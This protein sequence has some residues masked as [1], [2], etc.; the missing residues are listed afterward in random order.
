MNPTKVRSLLLTEKADF[1]RQLFRDF[2]GL[3]QGF[4]RDSIKVLCKDSIKV[5]SGFTK[6]CIRF[7][8]V[9]KGFYKGCIKGSTRGL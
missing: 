8:R 5:P 4:I 6:G 7:I 3:L 2:L 1:T 9:L